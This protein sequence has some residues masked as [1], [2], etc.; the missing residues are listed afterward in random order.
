MIKIVICFWLLISIVFSVINTGLAQVNSGV[1]NMESPG[2]IPVPRIEKYANERVILTA[3]GKVLSIFIIGNR[4]EQ[5]NPLGRGLEL[6][7]KRIS[8]LGGGKLIST[9]SFEKARILVEYC[10]KGDFKKIIRKENVNEVPDEKRLSQ[11]YFLNIQRQKGEKPLIRLQA[12]TGLGLYYGLVSLCQLVERNQDGS[13]EVPGIFIVDWPETSLRLAKTSA[14]TNPMDR[15]MQFTDWMPVYKINMVGLQ[16]HGTESKEPGQFMDNVKAICSEQQ[17]KKL[18]ETVVYFCPFRGVGYDFGKDADKVKYIDLIN[19]TFDQ[20]ANGW[21]IDYNDWPDKNMPIE[22]VVNFAVQSVEAKKPDAYIFY[23]P[24]NTGPA[25]YRGPASL[26][27]TQTLSKIP[28]NVWPLWT[29]MTTIVSDTLQ[30]E[31][32]EQWTKDAGRRPFFWINRASVGVDK[33]FSRALPGNPEAL[34]VPAELLPQN[35]NSLFEGVHLN[36]VFSAGR[37]HTLPEKVSDSERIY[38][39]TLADYLWNPYD[40]N[41]VESHKR[42]KHF[43]EVMLPLISEE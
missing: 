43:V 15:L 28:K 17:Q 25:Q 30:P 37:S 35:L 7:S 36:F 5:E 21:E 1:N 9:D 19:W 18:L 12:T 16:F 42:A 14:T 20:G 4:N 2:I 10:S 33:S 32:V 13:I 6:F 34:V 31:M 24:P 41:D 23:C 39:A 22:N 3:E 40:W 8:R 11:A 38:F 26:E 29:G 27:M